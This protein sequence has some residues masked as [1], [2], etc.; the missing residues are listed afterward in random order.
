L[1]LESSLP[2]GT[3]AADAATYAAAIGAQMTAR[4]HLMRGRPTPSA[5]TVQSWA[6]D[7]EQW[8]ADL[9][10]AIELMRTR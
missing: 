5:A 3:S 2:V 9:A 6:G 7:L 10:A 8:S 1:K 4:A